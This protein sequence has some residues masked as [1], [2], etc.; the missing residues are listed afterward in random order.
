[1]SRQATQT[2]IGKQ[3]AQARQIGHVARY[4][5]GGAAERFGSGHARPLTGDIDAAAIGRTFSRTAQRVDRVGDQ[6]RAARVLAAK[7]GHRDLV[8]ADIGPDRY[9]NGGRRVLT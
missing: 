4:N 7:P 1:M 6:R 3:Q 8:C 9:P 2:G 5:D